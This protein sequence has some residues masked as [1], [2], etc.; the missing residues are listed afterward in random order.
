MMAKV[1]ALTTKTGTVTLSFRPEGQ[2]LLCV[3][4][5]GFAPATLLVAISPDDT[6]PL[7]VLLKAAPQLLPTVFTK[8][9]TRKYVSPGL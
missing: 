5:I 2:T 9:S 8:D 6:V 4:K 3:R 7:T 1:T